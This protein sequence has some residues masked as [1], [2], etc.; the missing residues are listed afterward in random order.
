MF[1]L[2]DL[3]THCIVITAIAAWFKAQSPRTQ[4][5]FVQRLKEQQNLQQEHERAGNAMTMVACRIA[6]TGS[7]TANNQ[8]NHDHLQKLQIAMQVQ[9][10][11]LFASVV[12]LHWLIQLVY[13]DNAQSPYSVNIRFDEPA[14]NTDGQSYIFYYC[15]AVLWW[16]IQV[17]WHL[18]RQSWLGY[19]LTVVGLLSVG[20]LT[21][22][23]SMSVMKNSWEKCTLGVIRWVYEVCAYA[24]TGFYKRLF[25]V[26]ASTWFGWLACLCVL[27]NLVWDELTCSLPMLHHS[28]HLKV[29]FYRIKLETAKYENAKHMGELVDYLFV[30][31]FREALSRSKQQA[32]KN[33]SDELNMDDLFV[34]EHCDAAQMLT[35]LRAARNIED[36]PDNCKPSE[37]ER[38]ENE[39][40]RKIKGSQ[41]LMCEILTLQVDCKQV[42][43]PNYAEFWLVFHMWASTIYMSYLW[44]QTFGDKSKNLKYWILFGWTHCVPAGYSYWST[45]DCDMWMRAAVRFVFFFAYVAHSHVL[46]RDCVNQCCK[47]AT[48]H[49]NAKFIYLTP[50]LWNL[51]QK[52]LEY[53][54]SAIS[55]IN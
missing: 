1:N 24:I 50:F 52:C 43:K 10:A 38:I 29:S 34:D 55:S 14:S 31:L 32:S 42:E 49:L 22:C 11:T 46:R 17:A 16:M 39:T 9:P 27:F 28:H 12:L 6:S 54:W 7:T 51:V 45:G 2:R 20:L 3:D 26:E 5:L 48:R 18:M 4:K 37:L 47:P 36:L 41:D 30:H 40:Y 25:N 53:R 8:A 15:C 21:P 13:A 44:C 19:A 33:E 35:Y 23:F